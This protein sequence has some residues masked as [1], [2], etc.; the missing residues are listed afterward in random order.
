MHDWG[1]DQYG[2]ITDRK[3]PLSPRFDPHNL[4]DKI[5]FRE[6]TGLDVDFVDKRTVRVGNNP[7]DTYNLADLDQR[8]RFNDLIIDQRTDCDRH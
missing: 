8:R 3:N 5:R 1:I 4:V 6:Q 2:C 7:L